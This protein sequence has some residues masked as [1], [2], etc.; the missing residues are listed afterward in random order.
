MTTYYVDGTN[1]NNANAGTSTGAA[2]ATL[3]KA[4]S[5]ATSADDTVIIAEGTYPENVTLGASGTSGHQITWIGDVLGTYFT[6]RRGVVRWTGAASNNQSISRANCIVASTKNYRTFKNILFDMTSSSLLSLTSPIGWV[7]DGCAFEVGSNGQSAIAASGNSQASCTI[8]NCL[9]VGSHSTSIM[10]QF[11]GSVLNAGHV[12]ENCTFIG[13]SQSYG[14]DCNPTA[15]VLIHNNRFFACAFAV[16]ARN[17]GG[18][19]TA[20]TVYNNRVAYLSNTALLAGT[21]GML[22]EDYN[23]L[24]QCATARSNVSTGAGSTAYPDLCDMRWFFEMVAGG[25]LVTPH[26]MASY[27]ALVNVAGTSPPTTDARGTAVQGSQRE[28]GPLEYDSSLL[29]AAGG[30]LLTHPGMAG[31]LRG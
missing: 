17:F 2:W 30:G 16:L 14:I 6:G 22:V 19:Y 28:W 20:V 23:N 25:R 29:V 9:F 4:E 15:G 8:K 24:W 13:G 11:T 1:G 3:A 27:S 10:I 12:V 21:A 26:D 18:G 31:G 7:L 5:V